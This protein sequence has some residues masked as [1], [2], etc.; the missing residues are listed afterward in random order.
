[1]YDDKITEQLKEVFK[2]VSEESY[3]D[4]LVKKS[5]IKFLNINDRE[6]EIFR[7]K[8]VEKNTYKQISEQ[9]KISIPRISRIIDR[10][11]YSKLPK[12]KFIRGSRLSATKLLAEYDCNI[13]IVNVL[14]RS[15]HLEA[16]DS[17]FTVYHI[18]NQ[19]VNGQ[20]K[21]KGLSTVGLNNLKE[22]LIKIQK[23]YR[24]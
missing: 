16:E 22:I 24:L 19:C 6:L 9:L 21:I 7:L 20:L 8:L 13:R 3:Y 14:L 10:V 17:I 1:M 11:L 5:R 2:G 18:Y 23:D 4:E 12:I 15:G